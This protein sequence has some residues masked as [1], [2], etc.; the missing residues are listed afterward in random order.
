MTFDWHYLL[1][2]IPVCAW[3][4]VAYELYN[5]KEIPQDNGFHDQPF[6]HDGAYAEDED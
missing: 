3:A 2:L 1:F 4:W 5:A 6:E